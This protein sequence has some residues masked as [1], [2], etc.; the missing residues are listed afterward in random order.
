MNFAGFL[1]IHARSAPDS[2]ALADARL[3]LTYSELDQLSSAFAAG[4]V[5][6]GLRAG[7]R[8]AICLL[9]RVELV[10]TL[11][12]CF[13][14]GVIAAPLNWRL[15]G[16]DLTKVVHHCAPA[17]AVTTRERVEELAGMGIPRVLEVG[18]TAREGGFW[19]FLAAAPSG[20]PTVGRQHGDIANLLY[21]SGTTA[22]PK[23][24]IHTHGMRVSI[25]GTMADCFKLSRNDR[26]LAISPLF[27]TGGMS[28]LSNAMFVGCPCIL[29]EKWELG[30]FLTTVQREKIT[31][32]HLIATLI[33]DIANAP[34]VAFEGFT[35]QVR[36]VWGGGH[37]VS[38]EILETFERRLGGT[39]LLGYSRTEG[40]L[41]YNILDPARR[42]FAH[43]GYPNSNSSEVAVIDPE[44]G[45][46]CPPGITG[47]IMVRGDG[48]APG[49]WDGTFVRRPI[50]FDGSWQPT[51]D[52]G[53]IDSD[54]ALHFI[55][56]NDEMIKTGGENVYPSEVAT[57]LL[58][59]AGVSDVAVFG[60]PDPRMGQRVAA[61]IVRSD[62]SLTEEDVERAA[63]AALG[64]FKIP[65]AITFADALPRLGSQKIDVAACRRLFGPREF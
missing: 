57:A 51:G 58:G 5:E 23:A 59:L 41:T 35:Q 32:L 64:G 29:M 43:N 39:L 36:M 22:T 12:G 46:R 40:G 28:L 24:A 62:P 65:R 30:S 42:S 34:E 56:R 6:A 18:D 16:P 55:G 1:E 25:A 15:Q 10:I 4:I 2:L 37:N 7:D 14:A 49:Y 60:L 11:F 17:Y 13:K 47:E 33:V 8:V 20:F 3:R 53:F 44:R 31:F 54:G 61:V 52:L 19:D 48:V 26:A 38:P 50:L 9:N 27:H 21:T 63:R 45:E